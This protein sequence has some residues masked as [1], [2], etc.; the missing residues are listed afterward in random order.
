MK[1]VDVL[2]ALAL[3]ASAMVDQRVPK[4]LLSENGASTAAD[5]RLIREDVERVQWHAALKPLTIGVPAFQD[6]DRDYQEI[7]VVTLNLRPAANVARLVELTHRAIPYPVVLVIEQSVEVSI[8]LVHKRTSHAD[9]DSTVLD[10]ESR[11]VKLDKELG[12]DHLC[13][14]LESLALSQQ[15]H[16]SL[17][18]LYQGWIDATVSLQAAAITGKLE[19]ANDPAHAVRRRKALQ[20]CHVLQLEMASLRSEAIKTKQMARRADF[21]LQIQQ[22][23]L[24]YDDARAQL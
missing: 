22:L 21:N 17:Y 10:G 24:A 1:I 14:F 3:P 16:T 5:R 13:R 11:T 6:S 23:K 12:P 2:A 15:P 19:A 4:S 8:S 7:A 20:Q 9:H 18:D